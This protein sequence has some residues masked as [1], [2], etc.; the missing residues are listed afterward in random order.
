MMLFLFLSHAAVM[1]V[2]GKVKVP[3]APIPVKAKKWSR[4]DLCSSKSN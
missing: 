4:E 3:I 1:P 2:G